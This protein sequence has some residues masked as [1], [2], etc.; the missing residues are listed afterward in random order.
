M[1]ILLLVFS[2][3]FK[4]DLEARSLLSEREGLVEQF[5]TIGNSI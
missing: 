3:F 5:K 4:E 1:I 2:I